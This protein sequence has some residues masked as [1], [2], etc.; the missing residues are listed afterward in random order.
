MF[1]FKKAVGLMLT[2]SLV[3]PLSAVTAD[4]TGST[5]IP[6][7]Y[8]I[9]YSVDDDEIFIFAANYKPLEYSAKGQTGGDVV[10]NQIIGDK[11][12][13]AFPGLK[14][15]FGTWDYPVRYEDL[16]A[17]GVVPDIVIENP[18]NRIDRDLEPLGWVQDMTSMIE[19]SGIDLSALNPAAVEMVKSRSDGGIYGVPLFI[20]D[21][22]LYYN[23]K[24]FDK[25]GVKYPTPGMTYDEIYRMAKKLT[26]QDGL[27]AYKGFMQHPDNYLQYNQLGLYPFQPTNS[28]EP[29]PEDVKVDI[30]SPEWF[31]LGENIDRFL[32][33]PRN[34]FTTVTDFL[35]G[36]MSR[37]GHVAMAVDTLQKLPAYAGDDLFIKDGDEARYHEW[38]NSIDVGVTSVPVLNNRSQTTYQ[39]NTMAAFIPPQAR[40]QEEALQIVKWLV[41]EEGQV[42]LSRHAIKGVLQ[43]PAV[44]DS[45]GDDVPGLA[46][47]DT[48][49]VFWGQN[50]VVKNYQNTEYWDIPMYSVFRQHVLKDAMSVEAAFTVTETEDIPNYIKSQANAGKG[51]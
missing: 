28:E 33:L 10:F 46:N 2:F 51:W 43:T 3:V 23:K 9:P 7:K 13:E 36:D 5:N 47:V 22:M 11:L 50:A 8:N 44:V 1:K 16:K 30:T 34:G 27:D 15:K 29:A 14:I 6:N 20:D 17:A 25:F 26:T 41:S 24:I 38:L 12:R 37:P 31:Q 4:G 42:E 35:K 19:Q 48:S 40:H 32:W 18:Y 21:Y 45:F 39:P 49:G